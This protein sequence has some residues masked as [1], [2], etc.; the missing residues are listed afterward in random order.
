MGLELRLRLRL[1]EHVWR[2]GVGHG[3]TLHQLHAL[4]RG[5]G[6]RLR[7]PAVLG[8]ELLR[9]RLWVLRLLRLEELR[10]RL[11][12]R[13]LRWL[14]LHGRLVEVWRLLWGLLRHPD[15]A[16]LESQRGVAC[17][18]ARQ[19]EA[20]RGL[21]VLMLLLDLLDLLGLVRLR[22]MPRRTLLLVP[23]LTLLLRPFV[24]LARR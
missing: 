14:E 5:I 13:R 18:C 20:A 1:L 10:L 15:Q 3:A 9:A 7:L 12:V 22:A 21:D 17:G 2:G 6:P 23:W 24:H 19:H 4:G 11:L 16:S 8:L